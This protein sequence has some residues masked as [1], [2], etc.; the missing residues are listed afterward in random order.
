MLTTQE[1]SA[2]QLESR[3]CEDIQ[4]N[5][6]MLSGKTLALLV[7][8][9]DTVSNVKAKI[10]DKEH[11]YPETHYLV[12]AGKTLQ[13][14]RTLSECNVRSQSLIRLVPHLLGGTNE[15]GSIAV[16]VWSVFICFYAG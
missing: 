9:S 15:N 11:I 14:D 10:S 16:S 13:N 5:V 12:F 8:A 1:K 7:H 2:L 4:I 3:R 6:E